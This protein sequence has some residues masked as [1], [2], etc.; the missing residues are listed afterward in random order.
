MT[1]ATIWLGVSSRIWMMYSP[2]SVST[3]SNPACSRW[4][5]SAISSEI[6]DL[7]L[8][9]MRALAS[10][11]MLAM[12]S[13]A[14]SAVGAN[15]RAAGFAVAFLE[16]FEIDVEV[17][18][19]VIR[20]RGRPRAGLELGQSR[21]SRGTLRDETGRKPERARCNC[22]LSSASRTLALNS[23]V[24]G[25]MAWGRILPVPLLADTG[26]PQAI[27]LAVRGSASEHLE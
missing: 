9:M 8:V 21:A 19:R 27:R 23:V 6:I 3:T 2:R 12:I 26:R 18:E 22:E 1:G 16:L 11:Q 17:G 25:F 10:R 24:V 5:L 4:A 20:C 13:R 15:A 14:S 7:P